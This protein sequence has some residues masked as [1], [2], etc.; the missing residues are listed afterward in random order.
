MFNST[1]RSIKFHLVA[2][3]NIIHRITLDMSSKSEIIHM[4]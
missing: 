2:D 4:C 3:Y 1:Y